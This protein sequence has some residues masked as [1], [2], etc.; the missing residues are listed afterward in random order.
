MVKSRS[1]TDKWKSNYLFTKKLLRDILALINIVDIPNLETD[2]SHL[3]ARVNF[4][5]SAS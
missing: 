4:Y 2:I 3:N 1:N 5:K